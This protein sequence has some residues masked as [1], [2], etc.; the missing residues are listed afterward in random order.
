MIRAPTLEFKNPDRTHKGSFKGPDYRT[1]QYPLRGPDYRT[2]ECP[3][4]ESLQDNPI[5]VQGSSL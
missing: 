4:K 3:S 5:A 2:L 1:L